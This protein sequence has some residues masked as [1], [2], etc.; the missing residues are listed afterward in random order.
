MIDVLWLIIF[1]GI[2]AFYGYQHL[3]FVLAHLARSFHKSTQRLRAHPYRNDLEAQRVLAQKRALA[4]EAE[5]ERLERLLFV[6]RAQRDIAHSRLLSHSF[7][8]HARYGGA[9]VL[10]AIV[11]F[12]SLT[13]APQIA[14][15]LSTSSTSDYRVSTT[16][17]S[18]ARSCRSKTMMLT[19]RPTEVISYGSLMLAIDPI[20]TRYDPLTF[21]PEMR[22]A[23]STHEP[24]DSRRPCRDT[25]HWLSQL[26]AIPLGRH[27]ALPESSSVYQMYAFN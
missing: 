8:G 11:S 2:I 23:T 6:A 4:A 22:P 16:R 15:D 19:Y 24:Q 5:I 18:F 13:I 27:D 1:L 26:R 10:G 14:H 25:N 9:F 7:Q 21:W 3:R 12:S 20:P 17:Y